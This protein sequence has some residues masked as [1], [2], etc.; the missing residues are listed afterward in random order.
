[1]NVTN[2]DLNLLVALDALLTER[3]VTRA[4]ER[5]SVGQ[6]AMSATLGRL[7][8]LFGDQLFVRTGGDMVPT[9]MGQ[10]LV[11]PVTEAIRAVQAVLD[12]VDA[13]DPTTDR[14]TF[15]VMASDYVGL[16]LI[17]PL[18]RRLSVEAP[19]VRLIV[20]P[21]AADYEAMIRQ[22]R[23]DLAIL[24]GEML[25]PA[26]ELRRESLFQDRYV[27]AV[28]ADDAS[29]G[30]RLT[31][32]QL[33]SHRRLATGDRELPALG[34]RQLDGL[35]LDPAAE[36]STQTSLLAPF[37]VAG[38][39]LIILTLQR[40]VDELGWAGIRA[41]EP[42]LPLRTIDECLFW[43][44]R[45]DSDVGHRWLRQEILTTAQQL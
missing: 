3:S 44:I 36:L 40:L 1:M 35:T 13:F 19:E 14:R 30:D 6:P 20:Q 22:G 8:K 45:R 27:F 5:L 42:P 2:V 24:P 29:I 37:F 9:A 39:G 21:V 25:D 23:V 38:T 7:R 34:D 12:V 28:D 41:V 33:A 16:V 10:A 11:G 32:E 17:R 15:T 31:I 18:V 43:S 26:P 4:A